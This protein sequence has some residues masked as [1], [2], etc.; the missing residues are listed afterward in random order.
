MFDGRCDYVSTVM[1][2]SFASTANCKIVGFCAAGQKH[3][4]VRARANQSSNLTAGAVDSSSSFLPREMY[5]RGISKLFSQ[6]WRHSL[7]HPPVYGRCG[8]MIQINS[9]ER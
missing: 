8:A 5:A 2:R 6:K 7:Y 3:Y 4:L 9:A 1:F